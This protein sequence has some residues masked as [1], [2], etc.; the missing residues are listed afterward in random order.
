MKIDIIGLG[1]VGLISGLCLADKGHTVTCHDINKKNINNINKIK[2]HFF[3]PGLTNILKKN[4]L[5]KNFFAKHLSKKTSFT[6]NIIIIAVGTP[7]KNKKI[8]LSQIK[9][10]IKFIA[11]YIKD[12]DTFF[13]IIIKSTVPPSTTDTYVKKIIEK[14]SNK[15]LSKNEFGLGMNPEFLREGS[16][17]KDF[18]NAD[19][20]VIGYED[21]K[22]KECIK[23]IYKKW[24]CEKIIVN[25]RTAEMIKY[26]NNSLLAMQISGVNEI[27]NICNSMG[28]ININNVIKGVKSDKR[29][30]PIINKKRIRPGIL[31]Y[32]NPGPGF[33]GSC[34]PKDLETFINLGKKLNISSNLFNEVKKVND[35]QPIKIIN[36]IEKY[37][38]NL[39]NK[40]IL[41]LGL[42]F[43]PDTDDIRESVSIKIIKNLILL[44]KNIQIYAHDPVAI[45]NAKNLFK[46]NKKILFVKNWKKNISK[47]DI[48]MIL[49]SWPEYNDLKK[50][51][52]KLSKKIVIDRS[53]MFDIDN[54][55]YN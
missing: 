41:I 14:Y 34:F 53:N 40:K 42:S 31:N 55:L 25:S 1:Y 17:I 8:D 39:N 30:S 37:L 21:N 23:K 48:I 4:I 16:A 13:S 38:C 27:A 54:L 24:K 32:L 45:K 47:T 18:I 12:K 20:I 35:L 29:W 10:S 26:A 43:K 50:T 2:P 19:R 11:K 49:T 6:S 3:E 52:Y 15:K 46:N 44:K 7:S 36:Y 33:G 51:N 22:T 5:N 28:R 9:N